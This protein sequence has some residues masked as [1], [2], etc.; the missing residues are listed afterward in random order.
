MGA[1][2]YK[3]LEWGEYSNLLLKIAVFVL[4]AQFNVIDF[5]VKSKTCRQVFRQGLLAGSKL[6]SDFEVDC[7]IAGSYLKRLKKDANLY[8]YP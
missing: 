4:L 8:K 5:I 6:Q 2:P 3:P 1:L 7:H